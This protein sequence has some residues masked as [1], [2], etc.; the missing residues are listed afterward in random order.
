MRV[1]ELEAPTYSARITDIFMGMTPLRM[2]QQRWLCSVFAWALFGAFSLFA[3][4]APTGPAIRSV[5]VS[6]TS[7]NVA[8]HEVATV[9]IGLA[10]PGSLSV[11]IVDRDGFPVRTLAKS[12]PV[13]KSASFGWDGRND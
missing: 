6:Q 10:A 3:A 1:D 8:A 7:V 11:V 2:S 4:Q 5:T 9:T 13:G 12:Q